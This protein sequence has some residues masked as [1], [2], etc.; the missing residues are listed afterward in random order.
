M[1]AAQTEEDLDEADASRAAA[2]SRITDRNILSLYED[3]VERTLGI[4]IEATRAVVRRAEAQVE[5]LTQL[6]GDAGE[7]AMGEG[8][9]LQRERLVVKVRAPTRNLPS[10]HIPLFLARCGISTFDLLVSFRFVSSWLRSLAGPSRSLR[11]PSWYSLGDSPSR[12]VVSDC[13]RRR[14]EHCP[15]N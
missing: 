5:V 9:C 15:P 8:R 13:G 12:D 6:D 2:L 3:I 7:D 4:F 1:A 10:I 14:S 11:G